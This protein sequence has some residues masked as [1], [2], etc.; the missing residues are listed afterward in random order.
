MC[1][2]QIGKVP[3]KTDSI[4]L[5]AQS[6]EIGLIPAQLPHQVVEKI[7]SAHPS[8]SRYILGRLA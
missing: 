4:I 7:E 1:K 3:D 8:A 6:A 5:N 2:S